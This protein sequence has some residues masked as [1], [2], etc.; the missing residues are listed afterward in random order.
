MVGLSARR[1][2]WRGK[3]FVPPPVSEG[4]T[5]LVP[6]S[7]GDENVGKR[8]GGYYNFQCAVFPQSVVSVENI[9]QV[10]M[11]ASNTGFV[12]NLGRLYVVGNNTGIGSAGLGTLSSSDILDPT[13]IVGGVPLYPAEDLPYSK[14]GGGV[15]HQP[16]GPMAPILPPIAE[17]VGGPGVA[18][19]ARTRAGYVLF[20]GD[21]AE[22]QGGNGANTLADAITF[23]KGPWAYKTTAG[24]STVGNTASL[25][26]PE[27]KKGETIPIGT[28]IITQSGGHGQV[29]VSNKVAFGATAS[30]KGDE[31]ISVEPQKA[32]YAY[33]SGS[34]IK[35]LGYWP[36]YA[37]DYVRTGGP[38]MVPV[39]GERPDGG[40]YTTAEVAAIRAEAEEHRLANIAQISAGEKCCYYLDETGHIW[41][42]GQVAG[43]STEHRFATLDP[44]WEAYLT[45]NPG[46][47]KAIQIDGTRYGALIRLE[48]GTVRHLGENV[49]GTAG[50]GST[51]EKG[52]RAV[53]NPGLAKVIDIAKA[54]RCWA[55]LKDNGK[56]SVCGSNEDGCLGIAGRHLSEPAYSPIVLAALSSVVEITAGGVKP[57][58]G[59]NNGDVMAARLSDET[60]RTWGSNWSYGDAASKNPV[61]WGVLGDGTTEDRSVPVQPA[62]TGVKKIY[63]NP[64]RM[65][66]LVEGSPP[67]PSMSV[68]ILPNKAVKVDWVPI[69]G[70]PPGSR[71]GWAPEGW[72][73]NLIGVS[74][75]NSGPLPANQH[76]WTSAPL[77][78]GSA[79]QVRVIEGF[80]SQTAT[81]SGGPTYTASG[82][83]VSLS[84]TLPAKAE[85]GQIVELLRVGPKEKQWRR[86]AEVSGSATSWTDN[87]P[88]PAKE[89]GHVYEARVRGA[90]EAPFG[91][92]IS[93]VLI[94]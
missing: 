79:I 22:G 28:Q 20:C 46:L 27:L 32:N 64:T 24:L 62:I 86:M 85:P 80:I 77:P 54:E 40:T 30:K 56:I 69:A 70:S 13:L 43:D 75:Y 11:S 3:D 55:A 35:A 15:W 33:P 78:S 6:F 19:W 83:K 44:V 52:T 72:N 81:L 1:R 31:S 90:A 45:A 14:E 66:A 36:Q 61:L 8:G 9:V 7:W 48:D 23:E 26:I 39:G 42:T 93:D 4:T 57:G 71:V 91:T 21:G 59:A 10:G 18:N 16:Q 37:F 50:S 2:G 5:G 47:S 84:W 65:M 41:T 34:T 82:G 92:R 88:P 74:G 94:P 87:E 76:S 89:S 73:V 51:E 53:T 60:V 29:W 68:T 58:S 63:A 67:T 49:E 12:D 38:L 25:P 17:Y